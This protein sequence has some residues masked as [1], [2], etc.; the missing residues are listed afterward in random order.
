MSKVANREEQSKIHKHRHTDVTASN[1][2]LCPPAPNN[3][4]KGFHW[5][6]RSGQPAVGGSEVKSVVMTRAEA[7]TSNY[8]LAGLW[9]ALGHYSLT[10]SPMNVH[11]RSVSL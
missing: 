11:K 10:H 5:I 6:Q 4:T 8:P 2:C 3:E 7:L 9:L 1:L